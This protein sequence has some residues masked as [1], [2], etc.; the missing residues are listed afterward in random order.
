VGADSFTYTISDGRGGSSTGTVL[1]TL[2]YE[3]K[4]QPLVKVENGWKLQFAGTQ[5]QTYEVQ[6]A[7]KVYGPYTTITNITIS[8]D[9]IGI[10]VDNNPQKIRHFIGYGCYNKPLCE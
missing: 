7:I 8:T 10:F 6:R 3:L 5:K 4:I 9:G 1:I 2:V